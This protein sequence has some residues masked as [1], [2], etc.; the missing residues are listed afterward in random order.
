MNSSTRMNSSRNPES[1]HSSGLF[2]VV[3][4]GSPIAIN[5]RP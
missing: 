1:V 4:W 2:L 5:K 3:E